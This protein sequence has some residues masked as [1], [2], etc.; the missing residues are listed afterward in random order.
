MAQQTRSHRKISSQTRY[1]SRISSFNNKKN[2]R[3]G[4]NWRSHYK[5][6]S[7]PWSTTWSTWFV[8]KR[9]ALAAVIFQIIG[10]LFGKIKP[11]YID[12]Y[13]DEAMLP[14]VLSAF[15][16]IRE[17]VRSAVSWWEGAPTPTPEERVSAL[18]LT[19]FLGGLFLL[20]KLL[21]RISDS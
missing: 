5:T 4:Q 10:L 2:P 1:H 17:I 8:I 19:L 12:P 21:E 11:Y 9:S 14:F 6:N 13:I 7:R 3:R 16:V 20:V 15:G 18:H